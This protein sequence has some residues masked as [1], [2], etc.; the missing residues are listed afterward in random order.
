MAEGYGTANVKP[1]RSCKRP[2]VTASLAA[3]QLIHG[4][5]M[6]IKKGSRRNGLIQPGFRAM[7][8]RRINGAIDAMTAVLMV[9]NAEL[10][11]QGLASPLSPFAASEEA[12]RTVARNLPKAAMVAD[13]PLRRGTKSDAP[14][15]RK[16]LWPAGKTAAPGRMG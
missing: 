12:A 1:L 15:Y 3:L 8:N 7:P 14:E 10:V 13:R 9:R 6:A 5:K 4:A 2:P 11:E 16:S